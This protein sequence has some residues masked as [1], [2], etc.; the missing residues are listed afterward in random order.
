MPEGARLLHDGFLRSAEAHPERPALEVAGSVLTYSELRERAARIAATLAARA[1]P[2]SPLTAVFA[3]RTPDAFAG[4]LGT[5]FSGR[6]YVPLNRSHPVARTRAMLERSGARSL[7]TD[8]QSA[9]QLPELLDGFEP[10][11]L[12]LVGDGGDTADLRAA[13]PAHELLGAEALLAASNWEPVRVGG[14]AIAYVMFTSG[15]TGVPKG[16]VIEHRNLP[17]YLDFV[18]DLLSLG[19]TD[20]VSQTHDLTFDPSVGDIFCAWERGA[21]VCCPPAEVLIR[22]G[23]FIRESELTIWMAVPSTA[24]FMRRFSMLKPGTYP[25]LRH[26]VCAGEPLPLELAEAYA[27]AAPEA[28]VHNLYGPTEVTIECIGHRFDPART[29]R[30]AEQGSVP[31]GRAFPGMEALVVNDMLREVGPGETGELLMAGPQVSPGYWRDSV[32]TAQSFVIPP[33]RSER[34][35]RTGD[36]VR[37]PAEGDGEIPYL[38][39]IDDQVKVA[40]VRTELGD[41]E[42]A[43]REV[44][45]VDAAVAVGW[46]RTATGVSGVVAFV[47]GEEVNVATATAALKA[48]LP[49]QAV[50]KRIIGL[51]ELPLNVNGKFDRRA[52][53]ALLEEES[54]RGYPRAP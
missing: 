32:Q 43:V 37:R 6:G 44:T 29:P 18:A 20:R 35:Y 16:V 54:G 22:P 24:V 36:L 5:L 42:A 49:S 30:Y 21:C 46:P 23:P 1:E 11:M 19:P 33:G 40:G 38:G 26:I 47:A 48:R 15:S 50:P 53:L 27:E 9:T 12:V 14:D 10:G 8:A 52:L 4:L 28:S 31:I 25:L 45:G 39:R 13:L 51:P 2:E 17:N 41:V 3:Y 34:F 7:V